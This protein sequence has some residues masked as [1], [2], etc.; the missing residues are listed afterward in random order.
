MNFKVVDNCKDYIFNNDRNNKILD[1]YDG[2]NYTGPC[3]YYNT[4]TMRIV[5]VLSKFGV[6]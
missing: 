2:W 3:D 4:G 6:I 1:N 5:P